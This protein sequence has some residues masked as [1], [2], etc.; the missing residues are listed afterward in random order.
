[1]PDAD[2]ILE[3]NWTN[4]IRDLRLGN[5]DGALADL[6][7]YNQEG[8]DVIHLSAVQRPGFD[9]N[10]TAVGE[11]GLLN[12][13]GAGT[14]GILRLREPDGDDA[15]EIH[16]G[17][18]ISLTSDDESTTISERLIS[19]NLFT[20]DRVSAR[21]VAATRGRIREATVGGEDGS[22]DP[23]AGMLTV[24]DDENSVTVEIDGQ[25][26]SIRHQGSVSTLSDARV[27]QGVEPVDGALE[28]VNQLQGVHYE[29]A[30][31]TTDVTLDDER[32]V[33]FL[34]QDVERVLPEAVDEDGDGWKGTVDDAFTPVLV[35]AIKEQQ[36]VIDEQTDRVESQ[37][38]TIER[39]RETVDEHTRIIEEQR[40]TIDEQSRA[41]ESQSETIEA[42]AGRIST[43]ESRLDALERAVERD[44]P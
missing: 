10:I 28:T 14:A 23:Q 22:E 31:D 15:V 6:R 17:P 2:I 29:W 19:T 27:K 33:G 32:H 36:A 25:T 7:M 8:D 38:E 3:K 40:E 35:E 5:E 26:G 30:D 42:Q 20:A 16:A 43:L 4:V 34:A 37:S 18:R 39:Q 1:M 44:A 11:A 13:G 21:E 41:L 9:A 24:L 12:L